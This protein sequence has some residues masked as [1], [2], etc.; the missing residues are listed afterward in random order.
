MGK[1]VGGQTL[2]LPWVGWDGLL[3][4]PACL[5]TWWIC[6][7]GPGWTGRWF[8]MP[9]HAC[10]PLPCP[11]LPA[12]H[13]Y[14]PTTLPICP[15][16]PT[17]PLPFLHPT[18]CL[19]CPLS[20]LPLGS[21]CD[22][23]PATT[24]PPAPLFLPCLLLPAFHTYMP[25]DRR[26]E[27]CP[28]LPTCPACTWVR[29]PAFCSGRMEVDGPH[30]HT[31]TFPTHTP[32]LHHT[33]APTHH[34]THPIWVWGWRGELGCLF[35]SS[36]PPTT[37]SRCLVVMIHLVCWMFLVDRGFTPSSLPGWEW[38]WLCLPVPPHPHHA[39]FPHLPSALPCSLPSCHHCAFGTGCP[40]VP[41]PSCHHTAHLPTHHTLPPPLHTFTH[42]HH[43]LVL[44]VTTPTQLWPCSGNPGCA[45][46][47][48]RLCLCLCLDAYRV[49]R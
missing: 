41:M 15:H 37:P 20:C 2:C 1:K 18:L 16:L 30:H 10:L 11:C 42:T 49:S 31:T 24:T 9:A 21:G 46:R 32:T 29:M 39:P 40:F 48:R 5:P 44:V 33:P 8:Y 34:H 19:P 27:T 47:L 35:Y 6:Q 28:C 17:C 23:L 25:A 36:L 45:G 43:C 22:P 3:P 12:C 7:V 14:L 26:V 13:H 4:L 38:D